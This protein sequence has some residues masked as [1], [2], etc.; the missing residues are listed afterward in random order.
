MGFSSWILHLHLSCTPSR[1]RS[2]VKEHKVNF[3]SAWLDL[4]KSTLLRFYKL[5]LWFQSCG[6]PFTTMLWDVVFEWKWISASLVCFSIWLWLSLVGLVLV[7][8]GCKALTIQFEPVKLLIFRRRFIRQV[9]LLQGKRSW[10]QFLLESISYTNLTH[11]F[12]SFLKCQTG[13]TN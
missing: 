4:P 12:H 2:Q 10:L 9:C 3:E 6:P 13:I 1:L 8:H 11:D 5:R 7:R